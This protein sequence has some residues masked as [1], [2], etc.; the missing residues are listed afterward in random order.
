MKQYKLI[1]KYP[2]LADD[3]EV[4]MIV[5]QGDRGS[6]GYYS[7]CHGKYSNKYV[8]TC[9]VH[10]YPEFWE[11]IIEKDYEILSL[12]DKRKQ[13]PILNLINGCSPVT[14][15]LYSEINSHD[16]NIHSVKRLSDGEIYTIGDKVCYYSK[17]TKIK[18]IYFNEHK[19]LSFKVEGYE[20]PL[21][22]V[23]MN[24]HPHFKKLK[25]EIL[26]KTEDGVDIY[27]GDEYY[28]I[29]LNENLPT[30]FKIQKSICDWNNPKK[31]PLGAIQFSTKEKAEEYILMNKPLNL[32][33][34]DLINIQ[35]KYDTLGDNLIE[36]VKEVLK[37]KL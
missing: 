11:E 36:K 37:A 34:Q 8:T 13:F 27:E 32:S 9:E 31:P 7:P 15:I 20:A 29:V 17:N 22:G 2:S 33:I 14:G 28:F 18:S 10:T 12:S 5:G 16:W 1:K 3:W 24:N 26:F 35:N 30:N 4:G 23:F 25:A 6:C 21:T 19:Q